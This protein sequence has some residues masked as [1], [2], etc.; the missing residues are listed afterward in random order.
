MDIF[1][2]NELL[3]MFKKELFDIEI[4]ETMFKKELF[5]IEIKETKETESLGE[6][7]CLIT[8]FMTTMKKSG[9]AL[10]L[11]ILRKRRIM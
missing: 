4:K 1:E 9:K 3:P 7:K 11:P 10:A 6:M 5:D 2:G 8:E